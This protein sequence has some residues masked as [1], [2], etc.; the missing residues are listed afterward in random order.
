[1][2]LSIVSLACLQIAILMLTV[3]GAENW[4]TSF[5][6]LWYGTFGIA[7][8]L[9]LASGIVAI[10]MRGV[11]ISY[12]V[13]TVVFALPALL[14]LPLLIWIILVLAPLAD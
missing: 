6:F 4:S 1:M 3:R 7:V 9:A 11:T 12:R 5:A 10:A 13:L 14:A 2:K 8:V